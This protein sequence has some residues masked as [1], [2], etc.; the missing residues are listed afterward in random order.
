MG[1]NV[2]F[3][4]AAFLA[5]LLVGAAL[6]D[7]EISGVIPGWLVKSTPNGS[8]LFGTEHAEG[9]SHAKSAFLKIKAPDSAASGVLLQKVSAESYRGLRLRISAR[10]P[11][12]GGVGAQLFFRVDNADGKRLTYDNMEKRAIFGTTPWTRYE[13]VLDVPQDGQ[14]I[15]FGIYANG[16]NG[17]EKIWAKDFKLE[18]VAKDVSLTALDTSVS[19]TPVNTDFD[20]LTSWHVGGGHLADFDYGTE[21][22]KGMPFHTAASIATKTLKPNGFE[23]LGQGVSAEAYIGKHLRLSAWMKSRDAA[24]GQIWMNVQDASGKTL[25]FDNINAHPV[26]GTTDWKR[27]EIVVDVPPHS[28]LITFGFFLTNGMAKPGKLWASGFRLEAVGSDI[29]VTHDAMPE[30]PQN[31]NFDQ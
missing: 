15:Q 16:A 30:A 6:A 26:T 9:S 29:A 7:D 24:G 25:T 13:D 10:I 11:T 8:F 23:T 19:K 31:T 4:G 18:E 12:P 5:V 2:K 14:F 20:G 1:M 17:P 27:Y 28:D 3:A 21:P 22:A